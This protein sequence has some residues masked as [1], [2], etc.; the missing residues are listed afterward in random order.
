LLSAA[1]CSTLKL[2]KAIVCPITTTSRAYPTRVPL[3]SSTATQ[4]FVICDHVKTIDINVGKPAF[5]ERLNENILDNV[6]ATVNAI[7]QKE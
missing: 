6:L 5:V 7:I 2:N 4:G 1:N 3:D